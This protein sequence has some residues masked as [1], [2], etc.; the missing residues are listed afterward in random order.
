MNSTQTVP[1][2][3]I[4]PFFLGNHMKRTTENKNNNQSVNTPIH[5]NT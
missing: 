3:N 4:L 2:T 5:Q 1:Y